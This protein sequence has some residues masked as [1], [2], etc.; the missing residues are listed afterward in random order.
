MKVKLLL[1]ALTGTALVTL[2]AKDLVLMTVNGKDIH[3][4]EFE[5]LYNKNKKQE[6]QKESF[7]QYLQRFIT[8]K[9]KVADAEA[10]KIEEQPSFKNEFNGYKGEL[11]KPFLEDTTVTER[12]LQEAYDRSTKI[13][14]V[15]HIMLPMAQTRDANEKQVAKLDSIR[16]CILAGQDFDTLAK[17]YT[18]DRRVHYGY[19][20]SGI[21][22]YKWEYEAYNTPVGQMSK[23]FTTDFGVHLI[24]VNGV[25]PN[26][27]TV[28]AEHILLIVPRGADATA[29]A[30]VKSRIDSIYNALNT[31][32]DFEQL[33]REKSEDKGSA[34][35][36]GK[37]PWFGYGQMVSPFSEIT[38]G[39]NDGEW[40]KPFETEYGYHIV[41][42]LG[43]KP[44]PSF[45]EQK[46]NLKN[47]MAMDERSAMPRQAK[48]E[49]LEKK[50]N[51]KFNDG[52]TAYL[53]DEIAK[54]GQYDS[55][56]VTDVLGKSNYTIFTY[57]GGKKVP[58]SV[59]VNRVNPKA[60]L[61]N[62]YAAA[63][64]ASAVKPY[65]QNEMLKYYTDNIIQE[66]D[67]Y[68]N[69][70]N[71]YRDGMLLFEVSN[72]KVW[73]GASKDTA[74]L[75]EY[76]EAHRDK[77]KWTAPRFKGII[78]SAVSD[79]VLDE[80]K[81][82]I[83]AYGQ[84]TLTTALHK[85]FGSKIKMERMLFAQGENKTVDYLLFGGEKPSSPRTKYPVAMVLQGGVIDQ[86]ETYADVKG[87]LTSDYQDVLQKQWE[88]ELQQKY[89]VVVNQKV[90]KQLKARYDGNN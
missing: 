33:A 26:P 60:K 68:S 3:V 24:R 18:I 43:H 70:L 14:D 47:A 79:S 89:K 86:P 19:I 36:G 82:A 48:I 1:L 9:R 62:K 61:D 41:K 27:G 5:Y 64:V 75:T 73:E 13:V 58:A 46:T 55:T 2:A 52:F 20:T 30:A 35:N 16:N 31:G 87:P 67:N 25:K 34:K 40:S 10:E 74:G 12:L 17:K 23:A 49:Q 59:L 88:Q 4:S 7:D 54:H 28:E 71:E 45:D 11:L 81:A 6:I 78:L 51:L 39:L 8:F 66:D 15:D 38:F 56:F 80:V 65:A 29:K 53:E 22:P 57:A 90:Y 77:Y 85:Q 76:F 44:V 72:R 50:Y 42:K 69:L 63:Y 83:P 32:G 84:D 37:L 21:F